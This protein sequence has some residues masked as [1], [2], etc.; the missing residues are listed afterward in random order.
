M[1]VVVLCSIL[2][3]LWC[4]AQLLGDGLVGIMSFVASICYIP[5]CF[6]VTTG[7]GMNY[8]WLLF[9]IYLLFRLICDLVWCIWG[10]LVGYL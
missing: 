7:I 6:I 8:I 1:C 4:C 2:S 10:I 5:D 3:V 9:Y